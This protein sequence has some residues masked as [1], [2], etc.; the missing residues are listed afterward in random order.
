MNDKLLQTY[1][2]IPFPPHDSMGFSDM[3]RR[4]EGGFVSS[5]EICLKEEA[6][7]PETALASLKRRIPLSDSGVPLT[8]ER[9]DGFE[10]EEFELSIEADQIRLAA[11]GDSG[12]RYGICELEER[13]GNGESGLFHEK[14]VIKHR[15][16]RC[17]FAPNTRP[18]QE[19]DELDDD[20]DYYP[21]AYL[22]GMMHDRLNGVWLTIYLCD[23][24][25]KFFPGRGEIGARKLAKLKKVAE[26]CARY[27]I[28][29]Y[30]YMA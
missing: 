8:L 26:K 2:A 10:A 6:L 13:W 22:D 24:P 4:F 23:M 17:F 18:P 5:R 19:L 25:T 15:I 29:C 21:D 27:G 7:L 1:D 20:V 30:L 12:F 3:V 14:P 28:K 16:T 9:R 11:S